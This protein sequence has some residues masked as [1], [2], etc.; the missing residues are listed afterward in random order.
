MCGPN[1]STGQQ[2]LN[3]Q[4]DLTLNVEQMRR[5]AEFIGE[6]HIT[7]MPEKRNGLYR[8]TWRKVALKKRKARRRIRTEMITSK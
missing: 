7:A 6:T 8:E 3:R 4:K 5:V 2:I 1:K